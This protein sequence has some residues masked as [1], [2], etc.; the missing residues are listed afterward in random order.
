M[1]ASAASYTNARGRLSSSTYA[2]SPDERRK[3]IGDA[4]APQALRRQPQQGELGAVVELEDDDVAGADA[5]VGEPRREA[6][7]V[8]PE[9]G[10]RPA[11]AARGIVQR[12]AR[13]EPV[14]VAVDARD[15]GE[16]MLEDLAEGRG[17]VAVDHV[18]HAAGR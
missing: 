16:V 9:L 7:D 6:A 4:T 12:G 13:G 1:V 14:A 17:V 18:A 8:G 10:V 3:L 15:V 11:P 5:G 2:V